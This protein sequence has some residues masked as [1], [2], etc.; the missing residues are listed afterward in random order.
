MTTPKDALAGPTCPTKEQRG[1]ECRVS[2]TPKLKQRAIDK[3]IR[4]S[5]NAQ[6]GCVNYGGYITKWGYGRPGY[7]GQKILSHRL[8]YILF[9]GDIPEGM[10][11]LHQCDNPAC[12]NPWHLYLGTDADNARDMARRGRQWC[13]RA[14]AQGIDFSA[15]KRRGLEKYRRI[16]DEERR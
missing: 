13:Q 12:I 8:S 9:V 6:N 11:V 15:T 4:N 10:R 14:K 16:A 7:L 3:L 5:M 2:T 1:R